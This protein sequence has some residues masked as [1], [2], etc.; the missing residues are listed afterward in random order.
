MQYSK[1][2]SAQN[3][4]VKLSILELYAYSF[5]VVKWRGTDLDQ[6]NKTI[7][8]TTYKYNVPRSE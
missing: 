8:T 7:G 1:P 3:A 2:M 6:A 5:A 4:N